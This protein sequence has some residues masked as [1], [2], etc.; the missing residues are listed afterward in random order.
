[1][2]SKSSDETE[3]SVSEHSSSSESS[4]SIDV[5]FTGIV[6]KQKYVAIYKLGKGT[7]STVWLS[8][9]VQDK[10]YYAIKIQNPDDYYEGEEEVGL[11]KKFK[12]KECKYINTLVDSFDYESE[13]GTHI[14]MV[15][16]LLAGST[17]DLIKS[18]KYKNGLPLDVVKKIIYQL[19]VSMDYM[20][21]KH[22]IIHT[23]IKP[24]NILIVGISERIKE[25]ISRFEKCEFDKI[26]MKKKRQSKRKK[27][28]KPDPLT[29]TVK[30][31]FDK[32]GSMSDLDSSSDDDQLD[33]DSQNSNESNDNSP[34]DQKYIDSNIITRLSD[35]GNCTDMN[36]KSYRIQTRYYRAPE[37][38]LEYDLNEKCDVWSV[39]CALY[40]LLTGS[41][42]FDPN[43]KNR[44]NRNRYHIYQF[45]S[46]LGRVPDYLLDSANKRNV[47]FKKNGLVKGKYSAKYS[48]LSS[49]LRDKLKYIDED[50]LFLVIDLLYK[51]LEYDPSKRPTPKECLN[52][53]W[54]A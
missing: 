8:Y 21:K 27:G 9:N 40:E 18:G 41:I 11:L 1:M 37:V 15:C 44:F 6:L 23:D 53:K 3:S 51:T 34:I 22:K 36:S 2:L 48:P 25:V 49:L 33:S 10:K 16:E 38:L 47:Y 12:Q 14:C 32:L 45:Q 20:N 19:L 42:L 35:F 54:F 39:G 13:E 5:D 50:E 31:V 46:K 28:N 29:S 4:M 17:F 43:K 26:Y 52:H 24:E 7:F 30:E